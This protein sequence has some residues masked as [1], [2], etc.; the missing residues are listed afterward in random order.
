MF[1]K[2]W[3]KAIKGCVGGRV[4]NKRGDEDEFLLKGD[5]N[6]P[7]ADTDSMVVEIFDEEAE[8]YFKRT[9]KATIVNG[10]L[11][12]IGEHTMELDEINAVS[13]GFLR[14]LLKKPLSKMRPRVDKFTSPVPVSR[15]LE[16]AQSENKPIKTID[17]LKEVITKLEAPNTAKNKA[18]IDGV[19]VGSI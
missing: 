9:N 14:D 10:Y 16:L 3:K 18:D 17:Y 7:K 12:E 6:D 4:L 2:F 1:P 13:D 5:P 15:L 19:Q 8:K 11:I